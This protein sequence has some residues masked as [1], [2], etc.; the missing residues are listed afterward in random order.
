MHE[1]DKYRNV[2]RF[3]FPLMTDH[4]IHCFSVAWWED[5]RWSWQY[6]LIHGEE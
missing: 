3:F 6:R 4:E 5:A 2:P 1:D